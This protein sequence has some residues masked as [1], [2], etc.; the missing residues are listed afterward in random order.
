MVKSVQDCSGLA[1]CR[2][3]SLLNGTPADN[4]VSLETFKRSKSNDYEHAIGSGVG[5][6]PDWR[7]PG[8]AAQ[9]ELGLLSQ[10]V[11]G[12]SRAHPL[13]AFSHG[14]SLAFSKLSCPEGR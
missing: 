12:F 3:G 1:G 8:L 14:P 9:Q 7:C 10:R 11:S 5:D 6:S 2:F 4:W 13:T